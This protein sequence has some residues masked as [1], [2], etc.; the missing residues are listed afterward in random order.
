MIYWLRCKID[1]RK[2]LSKDETTAIEPRINTHNLIGGGL[3]AE[4][5]TDDARL[6]TSIIKTATQYHGNSLNY[7]EVEN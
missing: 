5:R 1:R 7:M 3:Y 6:T 2:M 4:Y